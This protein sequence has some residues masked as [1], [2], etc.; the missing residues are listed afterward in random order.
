MEVATVVSRTEVRGGGTG[1]RALADVVA[2]G[3]AVND[4]RGG[5]GYMDA[6]ASTIVVSVPSA[7]HCAIYHC[8]RTG[9]ID[10]RRIIAV[11]IITSII[12]KKAAVNYSSRG[13]EPH[14]ATLLITIPTAPVGRATSDEAALYT[15]ARHPDVAAVAV[16]PPR[17]C[18]TILDDAVGD[19][20]R[21]H[22][23]M[24]AFAAVRLVAIAGNR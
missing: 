18:A 12:F 24:T 1:D 11:I 13:V 4:L 8:R 3:D 15:P 19:K 20:T 2:V 9:N 22:P 23:D 7:S 14:T 21:R 16:A 17:A 5:I 6:R 10:T